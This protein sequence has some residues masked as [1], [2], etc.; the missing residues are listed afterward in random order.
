MSAGAAAGAEGSTGTA[1]AV[2][3]T[4]LG[5]EDAAMASGM[6][7]RGTGTMI[8]TEGRARATDMS[9]GRAG[10]AGGS[11]MIRISIAGAA[12]A[13]G[14]ATCCGRRNN[15]RRTP[16]RATAARKAGRRWRQLRREESS[17]LK[18]SGGPRITAFPSELTAPF[19]TAGNGPCWIAG[20]QT[21][22]KGGAFGE[23]DGITDAGYRAAPPVV[24]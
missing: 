14:G 1:A 4:G 3:A 17:L 9:G 24:R 22:W 19:K 18:E 2:W 15:A 11:L 20:S 21:E 16:C 23:R 6:V 5:V 7:M 10:C 8:R 13:I 12:G